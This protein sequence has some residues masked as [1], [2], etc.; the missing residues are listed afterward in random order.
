MII[1]LKDGSKREVKEGISVIELA[2][3]ISEGLA[4]VATAGRVDGKVVDLRYNLNKDC[5]VENLTFDDE[6]WKKAYWHTTTHK[7]AQANKTKYKDYAKPGE[8]ENKKFYFDKF[9]VA[10]MNYRIKILPKALEGRFE[11]G[12][13]LNDRQRRTLKRRYGDIRYS[14][15]K[16]LSW[17]SCKMNV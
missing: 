3:E 17:Q 16:H 15:F 1:T 10:E 11:Y 4:R 12:T 5:K 7:M 2:K 14:N 9:D 13:K 6:D 8:S